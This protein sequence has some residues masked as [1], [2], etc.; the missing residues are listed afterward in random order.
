MKKKFISVLLGITLMFSLTA[1]SNNTE[2]TAEENKEV[3]EEV[4]EPVKIV[5]GESYRSEVWGAQYIAEALGYYEEEGLDVELTTISGD[6]PSAALFANEIQFL[7]FGSEAVPMFN[8]EG[9]N[10]KILLGCNSRI[11]MSLVGSPSTKSVAD[12]KGKVVSAAEPGSSPRAFAYSALSQAG[13]DPEND[14]TYVTMQVFASAAALAEEQIQCS[15][16]SGSLLDYMVGMGCN[17]IVDTSDPETH[18]AV[19]GSE[20]YTTHVVIAT[21][22]YIKENPEI[23]QKF[24]NAVYKAI[25]WI[26]NHSAEEIAEVLTPYFEG[27]GVEAATIQQMLDDH[28]YNVDGTIT[29]TAYDAMI[30]QDKTAGWITE[31]MEYSENVNDTF[32]KKA[33]KEIVLE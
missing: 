4:T 5:V 10:C 9:Q 3:K 12:L 8:S 26:Q 29:S 28:E 30:R 11:G 22:E 18:K 20:D 19:L 25:L 1:C 24:V 13:L 17:V 31:D 6:S 33:Q 7:F 15:Y 23:C 27:R 21:D 14:V 16:A 2:N 32:L